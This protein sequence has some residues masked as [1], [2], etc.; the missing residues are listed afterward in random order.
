MYTQ[1][2]GNGQW[3]H[4]VSDLAEKAN[5]RF[6]VDATGVQALMPP[7]TVRF[8]P[9]MYDDSGPATNATNAATSSACPNRSS[10]TA[11]FWTAAH[12]LE[13]GFRS[14]SMGPG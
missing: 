5:P 2:I 11:A 12:S 10:G 1:A 4:A 8:A 9:L 6:I 3:V 7:S 13:A 14:V